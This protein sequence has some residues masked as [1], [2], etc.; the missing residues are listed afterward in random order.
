MA[1]FPMFVDLTDKDVLLVGGGSVAT[2]KLKTL[3]KFKPKITVISIECSEFIENLAQKGKIVL[4]KRKFEPENDI[5][6]RDLVIV[7]IDNL[8]LQSITYDI[9]KEKKIPVNCVDSPAF[10]SFI[11]PSVIIRGDFVLGISTSGKAPLLSK[12][13]REILEKILPADIENVV[14]KIEKIRNSDIDKDKKENKM[15]A[16]INKLKWKFQ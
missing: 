4:H 2:R 8:K 1:L 12:T 3:L 14:R 5:K 9:C 13:T 15:K 7:A 16:L 6:G 10:C 11:F